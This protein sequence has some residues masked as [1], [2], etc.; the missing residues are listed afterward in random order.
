MTDDD[1]NKIDDI[2]MKKTLE[3]KISPSKIDI[4]KLIKQE[5]IDVSF[6]KCQKTTFLKVL[7]KQTSEIGV[8]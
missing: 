5:D 4:F 6:K 1:I 3:D 8:C 7:Y 2:I